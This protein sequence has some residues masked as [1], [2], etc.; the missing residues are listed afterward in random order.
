MQTQ[1][2]PGALQPPA[3]WISH[4]I[5]VEEYYQEKE[6]QSQWLKRIFEDKTA[7]TS[8]FEA[9][10]LNTSSGTSSLVF[11]STTSSPFTS[12][13]S[14]VPSGSRGFGMSMTAPHSSST[15]G[16]FGFRAEQSVR[17]SGKNSFWG[18]FHQNS[19]GAAGQTTTLGFRAMTQTTGS[20]SS[21]SVFGTT[22]LPFM[23]GAGPAHS[24]GFRMSVAVPHSSSTT[25]AFGFGEDRLGGLVAWP[26]SGEASVRTPWVQLARTHRLPS[27][28]P[29]RLR[30]RLCLHVI[31]G[32]SSVLESSSS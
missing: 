3:P 4:S 10:T 25:G 23:S 22:S 12:G 13:I 2:S 32:I 16:A 30:T 24:G 27:M 5:K 14:A 15:T 19:L 20:G 1:V 7:I 18:G 6:A 8:A 17:T 9:M 28:W 29:A 26:L 11:G 21:C 31:F